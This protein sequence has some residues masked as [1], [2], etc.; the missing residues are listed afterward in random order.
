MIE[1]EGESIEV[2]SYVVYDYIV[3]PGAVHCQCHCLLAARR[4]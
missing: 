3:Q 4:R 2:D 1:D